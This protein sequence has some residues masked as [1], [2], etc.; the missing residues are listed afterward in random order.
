MLDKLDKKLILLYEKFIHFV[1][2]K[3]RIITPQMMMMHTDTNNT[4]HVLFICA[5]AMS[6][7]LDTVGFVLIVLLSIMLSVRAVSY[8]RG[9]RPS[10]LRDID[11]YDKNPMKVFTKYYML[12]MFARRNLDFGRKFSLAIFLSVG[13]SVVLIDP[14]DPVAWTLLLCLLSNTLVDYMFCVTPSDP[15]L[16]DTVEDVI[17]AILRSV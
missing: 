2:E 15:E 16:E 10:M 1:Q 3:Y 7:T 11:T 9:L 5:L 14:M 8:C 6:P 4:L 13:V 17:D 12:A